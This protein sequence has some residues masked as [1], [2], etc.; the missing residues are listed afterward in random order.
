[1]S[2]MEAKEALAAES[3]QS[4]ID[5]Y[6]RAVKPIPLSIP[7]G[8]VEAMNRPTVISMSGSS[9]SARSTGPGERA[10]P[11]IPCESMSAQ[12]VELPQASEIL[13]IAPPRDQS[14]TQTGP[15]QFYKRLS[16]DPTDVS[17]E[18][19]ESF[20]LAHHRAPS[21][22]S[23]EVQ[24]LQVYQYPNGS[25]STDASD[26]QERSAK[27]LVTSL[28][29][30]VIFVDA[31]PDTDSKELGDRPHPPARDASTAPS[32]V[33][34]PK[35]LMRRI[36]LKEASARLFRSV[37]LSSVDAKSTGTE[38][39]DSPSAAPETATGSKLH[40]V[41]T[42]ARRTVSLTGLAKKNTTVTVR[43]LDQ[44]ADH[45]WRKGDASPK[46]SVVRVRSL[47]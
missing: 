4:A 16:F 22:A 21:S 10:L 35:N 5:L 17:T 23:T 39:A 11:P 20:F 26:G 13:P 33:A 15:Y 25:V 36:S 37:S 42:R 19:R 8:S 45:E 46:A 47:K 31:V 12:P 28:E 24:E 29:P 2:R 32:P 3:H 27:T 7:A 34:P 40:D 18:G 1:M 14:K 43:S 30:R 6:G 9:I 41:W 38:S 44:N